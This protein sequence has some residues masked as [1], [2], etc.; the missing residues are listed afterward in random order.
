MLVKQSW[1]WL[2][3]HQQF[4]FRGV[5]QYNDAS[6]EA[7]GSIGTVTWRQ[8]SCVDG[9]CTGL[10][11]VCRKQK[12]AE[13]KKM[14]RRKPKLIRRENGRATCNAQTKYRKK[15]QGPK[16]SSVPVETTKSE[17]INWLE[18]LTYKLHF[19]WPVVSHHLTFLLCAC[20]GQSLH[21]CICPWFSR[22]YMKYG[23]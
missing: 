20:C 9:P 18:K 14:V 4:L 7:I 11:W 19:L 22:M 15:S 23:S 1:E 21:H 17:H 8:R 2:Q 5:W 10:E 12:D 16:E 13:S 6:K 3:I